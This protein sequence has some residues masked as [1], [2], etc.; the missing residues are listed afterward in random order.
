MAKNS[1]F[2]SSLKSQRVTASEERENNHR[3]ITT[4][5]CHAQN[6]SHGWEGRSWWPGPQAASQIL[7]RKRENGLRVVGNLRKKWTL[8]LV[9]RGH[10]QGHSQ[11]LQCHT[12]SP[13]KWG[14]RLF[15]ALIEHN[16]I[17][18]Q[19]SCAVVV[20]LRYRILLHKLHTWYGRKY[21][22]TE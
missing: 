20:S 9:A 4:D 5:S 8:L 6:S 7:S 16:T 13:L 17:W 14:T 19:W 2:A 12:V 18:T 11:M 21:N 1:L 22:R 3:E 10:E 15:Y